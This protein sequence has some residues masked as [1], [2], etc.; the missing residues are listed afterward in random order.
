[1]GMFTRM[2]SSIISIV[3]VPS[4]P[5]REG[6]EARDL[7]FTELTEGGVGGAEGVVQG[8]RLRVQDT[9]RIPATEFCTTPHSL[10]T[11]YVPWAGEHGV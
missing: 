8:L 5:F 7:A 10:N 11:A 4:P 6:G 2:R 1:M 9:C 3:H